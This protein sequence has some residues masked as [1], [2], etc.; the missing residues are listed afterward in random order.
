MVLRLTIINH[1]NIFRSL[2][3]FPSLEFSEIELKV[4]EGFLLGINTFS[5][6][7][8]DL[9]RWNKSSFSMENVFIPSKN[10]LRNF[11]LNF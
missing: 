9:C 4:Y 10:P 3:V 2:K 5:M 11:E 8:E 1:K 7:K 6:L